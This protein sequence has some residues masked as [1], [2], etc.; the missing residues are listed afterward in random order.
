MV[1]E[2]Q[3]YWLL[4]RPRRF[5]KTLLVDTLEAYFKG[6]AGLFEDTNIYRRHIESFLWILKYRRGWPKHPVVRLDFSSIEAESFPQFYHGLLVLLQERAKDHGINLDI[7]ES[8]GT[9]LRQLIEQL[10]QKYGR[11]VVILIDEYES[12]Y[13]DIYVSNKGEASQVLGTLQDFYRILKGLYKSIRFCFTTGI[14]SL[15][16]SDCFLSGA[17]NIRDITMNPDYAGIVGFNET[18]LTQYFGRFIEHVANRKGNTSIEILS[19]MRRWYG[20]FRF[21]VK[22]EPLYSPTSVIEYLRSDGAS[23]KSH[24]GTD[25]S[26]QFLT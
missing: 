4:R 26:S 2:T 8:V 17:N 1:K 14:T 11:R 20:G 15:T 18:E 19:E 21:T 3:I 5:G 16:L 13:K 22:N 7:A 23:I 10:G 6:E 25:R 24:S 9:V 12:P